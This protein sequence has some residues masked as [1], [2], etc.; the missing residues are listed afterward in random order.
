MRHSSTL[1][2]IAPALVAALAKIEGAYKD[3]KNPHFKNGYA[4]LESV[5]NASKPILTEH[6]ITL[7]QFPGAADGGRI[8]LETVLMH[9]SGEWITG[10]AAFQIPLEKPSAQAAGSALTYMRRYAQM[11]ALNI[12]AVDDDGEA[13]ASHQEP[14]RKDYGPSAIG[15][16]WWG[17][18]G[19]GPSAYQ[20][21]KE[22][23]D[24]AHEVMREEIGKLSSASE[25]RAWCATNDASIKAMPKSW[26]IELRNDAEAIAV[27]LG[28]DFNSRKA[29]A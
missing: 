6:G 14:P 27:E 19:A 2:A 13:A 24:K 20:A 18:D 7:M 29:A 11:A 12:P 26:R 16:D 10:D 23:L 25:W 22:G 4:S 28:V 15:K 9:E 8:G 21:K 3:S 17:C 1:G 5:I